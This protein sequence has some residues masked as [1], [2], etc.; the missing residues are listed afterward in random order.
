MIGMSNVGANGR[1]TIGAEILWDEW[2]VPH[3]FAADP[4]S[5]ARAFGWAQMHAHGDLILR[6]YGQARGRAA[7]YWGEAYLASDRLARAMGFPERAAR[8]LEEQPPRFQDYLSAFAAGMNAYAEQHADRL[9]EEARRALPITPSDVLAHAQRMLFTFLTIRGQMA[10]PDQPLLLLTEGIPLDPGSNGWAIGPNYTRDGHSLLLANPHL[11]WDDLYVW[12]EAQHVIPGVINFTGVGLV[13]S[14]VLTIGFNDHLG[15]TH[16]VNTHK[17]WDAYLLT[18]EGDGYRWDG[19]VRPFEVETQTL[20]VRQPDGTLREEELQIRRSVHGPVLAEVN[21]KPVAVRV[22]G[23]DQAPMSGILQQWWEMCCAKNLEQFE[24]ALRRLQFPMFNVIYADRDGH[25]LSL[26]GGLVP[27][28]PSGEWLDWTGLIPG[29]TSATLWTEVH[30]YE[31]LPRVIDPPSGWVQNSNSSPW[32]TTMPPAL[33]PADFPGY[34][35]AT[36]MTLREQ[37]AIQMITEHGPLGFDDVVTYHGDTHLRITDL[38]LDELIVAARE[39]GSEQ[40]RAAADI[41][42][43]WDRRAEPE[44]R[45]AALFALWAYEFLATGQPFSSLFAERWDLAAPLTTPRGLA[46]PAAAVAMLETAAAKLQEMA[47][48]LDVPFADRFRLRA[49]GIDLPANG[50]QDPFG[51]FR[52]LG[53]APRED[54]RFAAVTGTSYIAI[55]EFSDPVRAQTLLAYGNASQPGSPHVG[56][57]LQLYARKEM[58]PA[59]R[60]RSVIEQHLTRREMIG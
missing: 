32:T 6:L 5:L 4:T 51:C 18:P 1:S 38:I 49:D 52:Y 55:V 19:E 29:D 54:G 11:P 8:W 23:F 44:S 42:A 46:D 7:E 58:R 59:W 24:T 13:G 2:G 41:L 17:G 34:L 36:Q 48:S 60:T 57:Q 45:G 37:R 12:S 47:G 21:G 3:I 25:I 20:R 50:F 16:T 53:Y 40:A 9:S 43:A 33:D 26:F 14:P 22:V 15:W 56:D 28:R 31:D 10:N 27:R 35:S 30:P 39:Q